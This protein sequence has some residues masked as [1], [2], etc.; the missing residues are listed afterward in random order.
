MKI[1]FL[2]DSHHNVAEEA[3]ED[4][5]SPFTPAIVNNHIFLHI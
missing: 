5:G 4:H 3:Q 1:I 2:D